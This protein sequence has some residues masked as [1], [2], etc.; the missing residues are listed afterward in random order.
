[1][2]IDQD[3]TALNDT[4]LNDTALNDTGHDGSDEATDRAPD[5]RGPVLR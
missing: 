1:M 5:L 4:A 2:G 3:D